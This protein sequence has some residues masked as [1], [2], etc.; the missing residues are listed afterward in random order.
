FAK[1]AQLQA[2][3]VNSGNANACTGNQGLLDAQVMRTKTAENL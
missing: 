3:I 2:I 1:D